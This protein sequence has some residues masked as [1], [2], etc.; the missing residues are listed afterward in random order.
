MLLIEQKKLTTSF[1][2]FS[3][4][5]SKSILVV[6]PESL[7]LSSSSGADCR[8][9]ESWLQFVP[10]RWQKI[11]KTHLRKA[12]YQYDKKFINSGNDD[13]AAF[14]LLDENAVPTFVTI[15]TAPPGFSKTLFAI[16]FE[17][18][19][20]FQPRYLKKSTKPSAA[21]VLTLTVI[22]FFQ[23]HIELL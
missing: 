6:P 18:F 14:G 10:F 13:K 23:L 8:W 20:P 4:R 9:V 7:W 17:A 5:C 15:S 12:L 1:I 16:F 21:F 3:N 19:S 2:S 11:N 22:D